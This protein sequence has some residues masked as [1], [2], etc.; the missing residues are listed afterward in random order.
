MKQITTIYPDVKSG[1]AEHRTSITRKFQPQQRVSATELAAQLGMEFPS[2]GL[3]VVM[4]DQVGPVAVH[5][6]DFV[7]A[8]SC[9]L[10]DSSGQI[11]TVQPMMGG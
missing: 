1:L 6:E 4:D 10:T 5:A 9:F 8:G 3:P 11:V 7:S 2:T